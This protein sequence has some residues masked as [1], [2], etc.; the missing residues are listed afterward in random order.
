MLAKSAGGLPE[1]LAQVPS[2]VSLS[3]SSTRSGPSS[4]TTNPVSSSGSNGGGNGGKKSSNAGAIA[5][6]VIGGLVFLGAVG[7]GV[8]WFLRKRGVARGGTGSDYPGYPRY[9]SSATMSEQGMQ[10]SQM[11][12][13]VRLFTLLPTCILTDVDR[14]LPILPPS[15]HMVITKRVE[16]TPPQPARVFTTVSRNCERLGKVVFFCPTRHSLSGLDLCY[17]ILFFYSI[18]RVDCKMYLPSLTATAPCGFGFRSSPVASSL[19]C[20]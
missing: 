16:H 2:T 12:L 14:T 4:V 11:R 1:E 18:H 17:I 9:S 8:W 6:G 20:T 3:H 7:A 15:P 10:P 19:V 5:G 13:Y